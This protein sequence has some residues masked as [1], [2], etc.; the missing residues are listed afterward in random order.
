MAAQATVP[1]SPS[2]IGIGE[3]TLLSA[4]VLALLGAR[5]RQRLRG[6]LPRARV[7]EPSAESIAA[8]R[9]LRTLDAGERLLRLDVA[10]RA[11]AATL[12]EGE[13][14][15][16]VVRVGGD[17]AVELH[18]TDDAT[19]P[20][21][22]EG[23]RSCWELPGSTPVELLAEPARSVGA[24]CVALVQVGVDPDG[25]EVLVDLEALGVLGVDAAADLADAVVRGL[26]AT[27]ATSIFAEVANLVGVGVDESVFLDHRQAHVAPSVDAALELAATLV[28]STG[29]ARQSTFVLRARHTSGE[30]WEPAVVLASSSAAADL[31]PDVLRP[32]MRRSG[33]LAVVAAGATPGA[34]WHLRA[35]EGHWRLEPI[36][37]RLVPV[38]LTAAE[39]D[40]LHDVLRH[41]DAPLVRDEDEP[42]TDVDACADAEI[43]GAP[44]DEPFAGLPWS[45]LVRLLGPVEVVEP[46]GHDGDVRTIEGPR[47]DRLVDAAP[48]SLHACRRPHCV[49]GARRA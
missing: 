26:A 21:P 12:V 14:Q 19:L 4:G 16:A 32:A 43:V 33:G 24:P 27:L 15:V 17:G 41:A 20:P 44:V 18:L 8:E 47:A 45:L 13:A 48:R 10:L 38:G 37:I 7:P 35:G 36:G 42:R 46:R 2:P 25:R 40:E 5:R 6:S 22:W 3:A 9:R 29:S 49:V 11:A 34:P 31:T 1:G 23:A 39:V 30:A 28:G